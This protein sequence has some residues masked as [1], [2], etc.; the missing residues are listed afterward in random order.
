MSGRIDDNKKLMIKNILF[1]IIK[2]LRQTEPSKIIMIIIIIMTIIIKNLF[3]GSRRQK[4]HRLLEFV[5]N[6]YYMFSHKNDFATK[7]FKETF[8]FYCFVVLQLKSFQFRF[9]LF[10][11]F[12]L[13]ACLDPHWGKFRC[14]KISAENFFDG[15][16][17]ECLILNNFIK[18]PIIIIYYFQINIIFGNKCLL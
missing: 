17:T 8:L 10:H 4:W 18:M 7:A 14:L 5:P 12:S 3:F 9:Y 1:N 15:C 13:F 11:C 2:V 16:L 6:Y